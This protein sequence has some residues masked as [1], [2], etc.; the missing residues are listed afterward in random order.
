MKEVTFQN[1][2]PPNTHCIYMCIIV[3]IING[4]IMC[5]VTWCLLAISRWIQMCLR[6]K[7]SLSSLTS[8][9]RAPHPW[10]RLALFLF[11]MDMVMITVHRLRHGHGCGLGPVQWS[12]SPPLILILVMVTVLLWCFDVPQPKQPSV[13]V[14]SPV[15]DH[16]PLL[17][18]L[19][20]LEI[21]HTEATSR[22]Q[23]RALLLKVD[24]YYF[25]K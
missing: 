24:K 6:N 2:K 22:C 3:A 1:S 11:L 21:P 4:H 20:K 7:K 8:R 25:F 17:R 15:W 10:K 14:F 16:L 12:W 9:T 18:G 19:N 5:E 13:K 23:D